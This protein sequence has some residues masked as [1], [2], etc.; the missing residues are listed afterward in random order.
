MKYTIELTEKQMRMLETVTEEYFR[1]RMAQTFDFCDDLASMKCDL[2][3]SN[4]NHDKIF[5]DF[6]K[7]RDHLSELMRAFYRIAFEPDGY[8]HEKTEEMLIAED[9]WEAVRFALGRSR[10]DSTLH[11]GSE[12]FPTV[13]KHEEVQ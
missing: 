6:I 1:L 9:I 11:V 5:D 2:S 4:P 12:P 8:L 13:V 3:P 7:R 10:W